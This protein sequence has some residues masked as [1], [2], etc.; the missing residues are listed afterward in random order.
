MTF[1]QSNTFS[2]PAVRDFYEVEVQRI[3]VEAG[4]FQHREQ[5]RRLTVSIMIDAMEL[6]RARGTNNR[7]WSHASL[8]L[9]ELG[10]VG[11]LLPQ[12]LLGT[13]FTGSDGSQ[14]VG[15]HCGSDDMHVLS[16]V[17]SAGARRVVL[18]EL[19]KYFEVS[20]KVR[21]R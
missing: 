6:F 7:H 4:S 19:A 9:H 13:L 15:G 2:I 8:L 10:I 11:T 3:K 14:N 1:I 17:R 18:F 5:A 20:A 12:M 21:L 16:V